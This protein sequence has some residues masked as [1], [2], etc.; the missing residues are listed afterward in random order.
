MSKPEATIGAKIIESLEEAVRHAR[1]EP[2]DVRVTTYIVQI[3]DDCYC[4]D[5]P[6]GSEPGWWCPFGHET[7][8]D[9]CWGCR[10]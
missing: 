2:T 3:D 5:G 10:Y 6:P 9:D 8:R 7:F 4:P 1:G